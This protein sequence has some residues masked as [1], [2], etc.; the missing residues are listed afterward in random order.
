[1][2]SAGRRWRAARRRL[3]ESHR[4]HHRQCRHTEPA[5]RSVGEFQRDPVGRRRLYPRFRARP[6]AFRPAWRH[7]RASSVCSSSA[8]LPSRSPRRLC[9]LAPNITALIAAR[10]LQGAA[11]AMMAPQT[12]AI[13]QVIFPPRERGTAF[14]LFGLTAGF[15]AVTG[16][17]VGGLLIDAD[18]LGL[19]WRPIFL[20]NIPVG[21][22]CHRRRAAPDSGN[23]AACAC[24]ASTGSALSLPDLTILLRRVPA[25][26]RPRTRL[27]GMVLLDDGRI[28]CLAAALFVRWQFLQAAA[29]R[30]NCCP[31]PC[32]AIAS[33]W[34][35]R[36]SPRHSFSAVPSFFFVLAIYLQV[37]FGLP[38]I[39]SGLTTVPFSVGVLVSSLVSIWLGIR[40]QRLRMIA[41]ALMLI[42]A[43]LWLRWIAA[44]L[45]PGFAHRFCWRR[46]CSAAS[47]SAQL[48][49][50]CSR[51]RWLPS[52]GAMPA[53]P[54]A[55]CRRLQQ[56]GGAIGVAIVGEMFFSHLN[57]AMA[58]RFG[59]RR[60]L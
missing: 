56:V 4:R 44:T 18:I 59:A 49:R 24:S 6:A 46:C 60:R 8:L 27:A 58:D 28:G 5:A 50:R 52:P 37:G 2:S 31:P 33:S 48:F 16:P 23:A 13:A 14:A 7:A 12:L 39:E 54:R 15:A 55:D 19:E 42:C 1:M 30:R 35:V 41:G 53:R 9:G 11:G 34:Q 21:L 45:E 25:D 32:S 43:M 20:V 40:F 10:V 47:A 38:P 26:R 51:R 29:A 3:H 57:S 22:S 17:I 36:W